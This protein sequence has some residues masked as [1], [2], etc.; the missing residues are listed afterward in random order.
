MKHF[1]STNFRNTK[2]KP[3]LFVLAWVLVSFCFQTLAKAEVDTSVLLTDDEKRW[4]I[5]HP[6]VTYA[7]DPDFPPIEF[8]DGK[9][10][11]D[12]MTKD[13]LVLLGKK[14]GVRFNLIAAKTWTE[15]LEM[16]QQRL[17]DMW[18][19][20]A[21]TPQRLEYMNFTKPYIK[22]PAVIIVKT[23]NNEVQ[24]L[25]TMEGKRVAITSGY[26][27]HDFI[28]NNYPELE[29]EAVPNVLTGL[30]M[31]SLGLV[32]AM[33]ENIAVA[34]LFMEQD[35]ITNLRVGGKSGFTYN[36]AFA[37]RKD[38]PILNSILEKGLARITHEEMQDI[39][40]KWIPQGEET[41]ITVKNLLV[42]VLASLLV[43]AV[44]STVIWSLTLNKEVKQRTL[45]LIS[46]K[47]EAESANRAKSEFLSSMS[48]EL[49]TPLNAILGYADLLK[50]L[51]FGPLNE[52]QVDYVSQ[53]DNSGKHLLALITDLLD[54]TKIEAGKMR[55]NL[56]SFLP[57]E[58]FNASLELVKPKIQEKQLEIKSTVDT[59]L[60]KMTGDL[61]KCKQ[62]MLNLL[63][64]A[65]KY[66][67]E[68]GRIEILASKRDD[69]IRITVSDTGVGISEEEQ[70]EIFSE[71][72]QVNR[73]RDEALGGTG[74]G[75]ALTR[76]LVELHG[77]EIGVASDSIGSVF[78]FE[79]PLK[80]LTPQEKDKPDATIQSASPA[81]NGRRILAVEDNE[82]NLA[83]LLDMLHTHNHQV[84][85]ARNGQEAIDLAEANE[86]EL[87]LMDIRM[88]VMDGLEATRE[89]R[90][91][92]KFAKVP[93]IALT[94]SVGAEGREKC[95]KAGCTEH[96]AKPIQSKELFEAMDR[97]L[98]AK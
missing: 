62:I 12:G 35:G 79:L 97:Y 53:I 63:S 94:A 29:I 89:L 36:L 17:V 87:I 43:F 61:R 49:R 11:H 75:L 83:M 74:I 82:V 22:L 39:Y 25:D 48:H 16:G 78:W 37:S 77:G 31:V 66:T 54:M 21:P 46:A 57:Q 64:N 85:V 47:N 91:R 73:V 13:F 84:F 1:Q 28:I 19:G 40:Q 34:T 60:G 4:L 70:I 76:R 65:V 32:D 50:G 15:V 72:H 58:L 69:Y 95:L 2:I 96:L 81:V 86:P 51:F 67:P 68:K 5:E 8:L 44:G 80:I 42:W 6:E 71:F 14:M 55:L 26:A 59:A 7:S 98:I 92:N 3:L 23:D 41:W 27:V 45:E 30:R 18:S 38:W 52:K 24:T 20:A 90:K 88:P 10:N 33:I 93:I 56:E 9:N